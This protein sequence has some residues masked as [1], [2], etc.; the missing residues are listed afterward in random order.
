MHKAGYG[1]EEEDTM[2]LKEQEKEA[3][4]L[5]AEQTSHHHNGLATAVG[6][7]IRPLDLHPAL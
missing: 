6:G 3:D 2:Q 5:C 1:T 4:Q 7:K